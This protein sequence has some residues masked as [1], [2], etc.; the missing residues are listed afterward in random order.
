MH[1]LHHRTHG[2]A[3]T[4]ARCR[5]LRYRCAHDGLEVGLAELLRQVATDDTQLIPLASGQFGPL[6][7]VVRLCRFATLLGLAAQ[8]RHDI[9]ITQLTGLLASD[10]LVRDRREHHADRGRGQF[11]ALLDSR[12]EVC[13]KSV[14]ECAHAVSVSSAWQHGGMRASTVA[15]VGAVAAGAAALAYARWESEHFRLRQATT[16]LLPAGQPPL[17]ILHLSDLHFVPG[18]V[19]KQQWVSALSE[20]QPDAVI[21]TGDFM[22]HMLAVP[23]VLD[24]LEPLFYVPGAF[25]LGSNDYYAPKPINPARYLLG[26][27]GLEPD[28]EMLP[29]QDLVDGL[30]DAGWLDLSNTRGALTVDGRHVDIRGVDDPHIGR[31][32]YDDVAGEFDSSADLALGVT[33]AP[34]LRV[35]DRMAADGADLVLAGHTHGGQLRIPGL[36]ALVT[37]CDLDRARAR[38]LSSHGDAAL[39]VSAGLGTSPYAPFRFACP[40]EA[41]LLTVTARP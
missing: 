35:I 4:H 27:S 1:N 10:L 9:L 40:P 33:H 39:H 15:L 24:T 3:T 22:S 29:W 30:V 6:S 37:N 14:L 17:R 32:R 16:P 20:L 12:G 5:D 2:L 26:P 36:G 7:L 19:S 25:V 8:H 28:R 11:V 38:G 34:Y 41:T 23:H 13:L 31:D 21:A 18:Q